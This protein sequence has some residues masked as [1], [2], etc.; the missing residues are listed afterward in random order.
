[1]N[2]LNS[3]MQ[4]KEK[5]FFDISEGIDAFKVKIKL[6][7]HRM[8][9]GKLAAFPALNLFVYKK[10]IDLRSISQIFLEH[11]NSFFSELDRYIPFHK[12]S[13]IFNWVQSRFGVSALEI[14]L[15][16]NCI[17]E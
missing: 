9:S 15:E 4:G 3:S 8:E 11:F 7:M 16:M 2:Q 17:A 5:I 1:M 13:K 12:Y 14:Y 10:N 6:W